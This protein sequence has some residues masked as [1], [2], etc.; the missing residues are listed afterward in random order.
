MLPQN[1]CYN[2][3]KSLLSCASIP[4]MRQYDHLQF[5]LLIALCFL[6]LTLIH[7]V[8]EAPIEAFGQEPRY[9][10]VQ[11]SCKSFSNKLS[12]RNHET[13]LQEK[14]RVQFPDELFQPDY[15]LNEEETDLLYSG[16]DTSMVLLKF[17]L[18]FRR[19][20]ER[21]NKVGSCKAYNSQKY[22]CFAPQYWILGNGRYYPL[23]PK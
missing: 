8:Q 13:Q 14:D 11:A 20:R 15:H 1:L 6:F 18:T 19:I 16:C 5:L 12:L 9:K 10:N 17:K 21:P 22:V 4:R 7:D 3:K 2:K 23:L